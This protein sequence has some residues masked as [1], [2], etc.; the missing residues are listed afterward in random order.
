[1]N[2]PVTQK[3]WR[4][5]SQFYT[6]TVNCTCRSV[7]NS[8]PL[9][10]YPFRQTSIPPSQIIIFVI[11]RTRSKTKF[12]WHMYMQIWN[13]KF[14]PVPKMVLETKCKSCGQKGI[15]IYFFFFFSFSSLRA[16]SDGGGTPPDWGLNAIKYHNKFRILLHCLARPKK[17]QE[18]TRFET[19]THNFLPKEILWQPLC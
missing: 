8:R 11:R 6:L 3:G 18:V 9:S 5:Q 12:F 2:E 14:Y 15:Y 1:M 13:N 10:I 16:T 19:R 4:K 7:M 17:R